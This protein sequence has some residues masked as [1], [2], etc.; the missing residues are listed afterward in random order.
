MKIVIDEKIPYLKDALQQM[1]ME[2]V[3][4]PGVAISCREVRVSG[5]SV[6]RR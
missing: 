2:V 3:A 6:Q 4:L 1:G 5:L